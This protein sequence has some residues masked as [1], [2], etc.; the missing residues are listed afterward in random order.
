MKMVGTLVIL[1]KD[2]IEH[3]R[4]ILSVTVTDST[5]TIETADIYKTRYLDYEG[6]LFRE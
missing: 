1:W 3:F 5:T 2:L 6:K 4:N